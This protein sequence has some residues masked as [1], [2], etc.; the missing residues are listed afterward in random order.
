MSG[1]FVLCLIPMGFGSCWKL[2]RIFENSCM[3]RWY[4]QCGFPRYVFSF[5]DGRVDKL[6]VAADL[7][8]G[9]RRGRCKRLGNYGGLIIH[10][11]LLRVFGHLLLM[12]RL[13]QGRS[14]IYY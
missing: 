1:S 3:S 6:H 4:S 8:H 7:Y 12:F 13:L 2:L 14:M 10:I 11:H 9:C 5:R